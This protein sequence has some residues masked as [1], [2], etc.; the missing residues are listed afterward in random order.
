[1][2]DKNTIIISAAAVVALILGIIWLGGGFSGSAKPETSPSPEASSS[3]AL[4][5]ATVED[6]SKEID[7][8]SLD[9][10]DKDV[11]DIEADINSL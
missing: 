9:S 8:A 3:A 5:D 2:K 1:M 11:K 6:L 7:A 10:L 4:E